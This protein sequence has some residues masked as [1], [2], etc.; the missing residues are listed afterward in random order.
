MKAGWGPFSQ[1][2]Q[3]PLITP[4]IGGRGRRGVGKG[5]GVG[6]LVQGLSKSS[7]LWPGRL[8]V[9]EY[10]AE[11]EGHLSSAREASNQG[12]KFQRKELSGY[13]LVA[14]VQPRGYCSQQ[15]WGCRSQRRNPRCHGYSH[16]AGYFEEAGENPVSRAAVSRACTT[17]EQGPCQARGGLLV[18]QTPHKRKEK[19]PGF[20]ARDPERVLTDLRGLIRAVWTVPFPITSPALRD[21]G[22]LVSAGKLLRAARF[23][24]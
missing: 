1:F 19:S 8:R 5:T 22:D 24:G 9:E 12:R 20:R 15:P 17:T 2:K 21:A 7:G 16:H 13:L 14:K 4:L 18:S 10:L 3:L 11:P 6:L 23:R